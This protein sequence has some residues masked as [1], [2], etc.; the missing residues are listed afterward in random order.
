MKKVFQVM[1][2]V[3]ILLRGFLG[4]VEPQNHRNVLQ[5][6]KIGGF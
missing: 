1:Q 4:L 5:R 2:S 3:A 6:K